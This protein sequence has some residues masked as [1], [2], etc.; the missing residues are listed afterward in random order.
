MHDSIA[1]QIH[2]AAEA[3]LSAVE[4]AGAEIGEALNSALNRLL[5]PPYNAMSA[6]IVDVEGVNTQNCSNLICASSQTKVSS[7]S[8]V[9]ADTV[10]CVIHAALTLT[11]EELGYGYER[12]ASVKRL[13]RAPRTHTETWQTDTPLGIVFAIEA[14]EPMEK[15]A[16]RMIGLNAAYP[17]SEWPDM[18]VILTRGTINYACQFEA[19]PIGGDFLLPNEPYFPVMPMY[20]HLFGRSLGIWSFNRMCALLFMQLNIFAPGTRLPE[21]KEVLAGV[22]P[23]GLTLGAYQFNLKAELVPVPDQMQRER[24]PG[25]RHLPFRI[26]D[27]H[28]GLLS[29]IQFIP[30]QEGGVLRVV[31]KMPLEMF[32][33]FLGPVMK[34]SQ[35]IRRGDGEISS[36]LPITRIQ[37]AEMLGKFQRQSNMIVKP[38]QPSWTISK[39][40]DEGTS[41]PFMARLFLGMMRLR[42]AVYDRGSSKDEFDKPYEVVLMTILNTRE[43]H[44]QILDML[45]KH[46]REVAE[47]KAARVR[48]HSIYVD[49]PID[50]ELRR[51]VDDFLG[52]AVRVLKE[53]MQK[54]G[55]ALQ[56]DIGFLFKKQAAFEAG[57]AKLHGIH[58][59]LAAYLRETRKWSEPLV[60]SRNA[61]WHDGWLL[62]KI[63]YRELQGSIQVT[64]PEVAG[65]RVSDFVA[66]MMDRVCCF[67]E[68]VTAYGLQNKVHTSVSVTEVSLRERKP[69]CAER[70]QLALAQGGTP[71]WSLSYHESEFEKT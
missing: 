12:I 51:N 48:G 49:E 7:D 61:V 36:V 53:G 26:E 66:Y 42:D 19:D 35:K 67:V 25:L 44:K 9:P 28:G 41:S 38:E 50:K 2:S 69:D 62:P 68:E 30:W 10:A 57:I 70:F 46:K 14:N 23:Y 56:L 39:L 60:S 32:L 1:Q 63:G 3:L 31:G 47:G 24:A 55:T 18:V 65:Q 13:K 43:T 54:V 71:P 17:S 21:M 22:S 45:A 37:F 40:T 8:N 27:G 5:K 11:A 4:G 6:H 52:S 34:D 20:V 15:L 29:H 16:E 64:E 59:K 33:V 58:P